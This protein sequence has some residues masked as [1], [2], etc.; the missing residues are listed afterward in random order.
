AARA[1]VDAV[2]EGAGVGVELGG[3]HR[4]EALHRTDASPPRQGSGGAEPGGGVGGQEAV[5]QAAAGQQHLAVRAG[6]GFGGEVGGAGD[7][8]GAG[9]G[10]GA[11]A[12]GG[13]PVEGAAAEQGAAQGQAGAVEVEHGV[14]VGELG[15]GGEFAPVLRLGQPGGRP[16]EAE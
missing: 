1:G 13:G 7:A 15:V 3:R 11:V 8:G 14:E 12:A 6:D 2:V 16:A 4:A 5:F 9:D 10:V